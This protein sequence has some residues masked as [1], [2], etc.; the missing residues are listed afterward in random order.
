ML[1]MRHHLSLATIL[2][3]STA[4]PA[5]SAPKWQEYGV[6]TEGKSM[7][8]DSSSPKRDRGGNTITF[9]YRVTD[10]DGKEN[11]RTATSEDCFVGNSR[12]LNGHPSR[13]LYLLWNQCYSPS[14]FELAPY[15]WK[16][17]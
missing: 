12:A 3:L 14:I 10:R 4:L 9:K 1:T 5:L 6:T 17:F 8:L 13:K 7:S 16:T 2:L 11:V 15:N